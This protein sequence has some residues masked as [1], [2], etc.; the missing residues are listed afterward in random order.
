MELTSKDDI[1]VWDN[2]F[3]QA[4]F[5]D[6]ISKSEYVPWKYCEVV[7]ES[8]GNPVERF[9][10]WNIYEEGAVD[11]DPM[12]ISNVIDQ[13]C[14][15]RILEKISHADIVDMKRLRFNGTMKGEGYVMWPHADIFSDQ[16]TIWTIVIYLKGDGGTTIY[17][18][19]DGPELTTVDFKPNRAVMFPSRCW[20]RAESPKD[21]YFRTSL[22]VVYMFDA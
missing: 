3:D 9:M 2:F 12:Q 15:K 20:H 18:H 7:S 4:V 17:E 8:K 19:K 11:F 22:G 16:S 21:S 10:T 6:L 14:R 1:Y 5:D 13:T